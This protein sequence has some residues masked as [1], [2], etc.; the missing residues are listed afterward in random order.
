MK[1]TNPLR[2]AFIGGGAIA[3]THAEAVKQSSL[4]S[5]V[6]LFDPNQTAAANFAK[7]HN[8]PRV[9]QSL[10][11]LLADP[12]V[13]AVHILTPPESHLGLLEKC[14]GAG[15][16]AFAEK[17]I[18]SSPSDA[19]RFENSLSKAL[20]KCSVNQNM[21]FFPSFA[22]FRERLAR[23]EFGRLKHLDLSFHPQVKQLVAKQFT[24][25]MFAEPQ[26]ILLELAVHPVSQILSVVGDIEDIQVS[27][28]KPVMLNSRA[29]F[30]PEMEV[31]MR[32]QD[33]SVAMH[34]MVG[35]TYPAWKM[36][37]YCEDAVVT[38]DMFAD[39]LHVL[40][41]TKFLPILD[42]TLSYVSSAARLAGQASKNLATYATQQ[43]GLRP[44]SDAFFQSVKASAE[45]FYA[46]VQGH[47]SA[48]TS[49]LFGSKVVRVCGQIGAKLAPIPADPSLAVTPASVNAGANLP[50][51]T[52]ASPL[53][54]LIGGTGFIG[55]PTAVELLKKGYRVR[56]MS[57]GTRNISD[58]FTLPGIEVLSGNVRSPSDLDKAMSGVNVV[59][60]LAHGGGGSNLSEMK[61]SMVD[62]AVDVVRAAA[63]ANIKRV[64]HI[65]SVAG[66]FLGARGEIITGST[67]PDPQ[68]EKR[69]D[70]A[71]AKA[72]A[73]LEF[74]KACEAAGIEWVILRPGV[75]VGDG[76]GSLHNGVGHTNNDQHVIGWNEGLNPLPFVLADDCA[77][78][79]VGAVVN[80]AAANKAYN[81]SGD[82]SM[83]A[84][85]YMDE[86]NRVV[87]RPLKFHASSIRFLYAVEIWKYVIKTIGGKKIAFPSTRDFTSRGMYATFDCTDAKRDLDWK[88]LADRP[89]FIRRAIAVHGQ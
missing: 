18:F 82:V 60:N 43:I 56:I 14:F 76:T 12:G 8:I 72:L 83:S 24:H 41:R 77:T 30:Y 11:E 39:T 47:A 37:A 23:G 26:N 52:D 65:G 57:R 35:A 81:L 2:V 21:V 85:E 61:A 63:K 67:P 4:A 79:I 80:K 50:V 71:H 70:Y 16:H 46:S 32:T 33:V 15:K 27:T 42:Y 75:V 73:D 40:G 68:P 89:E 59:V 62:S 6:S 38:I 78:A 44:R 88:P 48:T 55:R 25:W 53:A 45:D 19:D 28:G 10:D 36:V 86:L 51:L 69:G 74:S 34:F 87:G 84:R 31:I 49:G 3:H 7:T 17:P 64:V 54:L 9:Y 5:I 58:V 22:R 29:G 13:D 1:I 66:L 20:V